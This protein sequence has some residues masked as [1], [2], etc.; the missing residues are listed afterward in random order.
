LQELSPGPGVDEPARVIVP[1]GWMAPAKF[2][3][4][5]EGADSDRLCHAADVELDTTMTDI[6]A[7]KVDGGS[8][9][10][11]DGGL[12]QDVLVARPNERQ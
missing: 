6:A 7:A 3:L 4:T 10:L 8:I 12:P 5:H 11:V 1:L 9:D 2:V